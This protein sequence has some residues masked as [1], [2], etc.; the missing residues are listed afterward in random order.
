MKKTVLL[1]YFFLAAKLF[2]SDLPFT[3]GV[4]LTSWFQTDNV[5]SISFN[6]FTKK[7]FV[8]IQSLGFDHIRLPLNMEYMTGGAPDYE[9]DPLFFTLLDNVV[10]WAEEL[11]LYLILDNHTFDSS[12]D[13]PED[14]ENVLIPIWRQM[15]EHYKNRSNYIIYE[16]LN[17]PHGISDST[18]INIQG[19]VLET[20]RAVD[21]THKI[22]VTGAQNS[23]YNSL[24]DI[25]AYE[26]DNLIYTFHFYD[27][28]LFTH[29]GATWSG[30]G[31]D[32][33]KNVPFPYDASRMPSWQSGTYDLWVVSLFGNYKNDGTVAK[34]KNLINIARDFRD[35][36]NVPIYCGE[37]GVYI[38]N[39]PAEDR[40]T[41]YSLVAG[42]LD[43]LDIPWTM[44][45]YQG[46]FGLFTKTS[47]ALFDY[48]LNIPL[49]EALGLNV[50][51]QKDELE[52]V[53]DSSEVD[54]FT[55]FA[56][57]D[58]KLLFYGTSAVNLYNEDVPDGNEFSIHWA[59]ASQYDYL[60]FDF[61]PDRDFSYLV[62]KGY[63][64]SF[65]FKGNAAS[66]VLDVRFV[67]A[68][69]D[70]S[71]DKPWR[72]KYNIRSSMYPSDNTWKKIQIPLSSF[73]E[74]GAY[75]N[76]TWYNPEGKFD[77]TEIN[78]FEFIAEHGDFN[79]VEYSLADI[80]LVDP[81]VVSVGDDEAVSYKFRLMQ[82]YP[83]PFNP[84]T[85]IQYQIPETENVSIK[86]YD[87]LG[88]E[89]AVLVNQT[90]SAGQYKVDFDASKLASGV[91][92]YRLSAGDFTANK[93]MI[94]L[95]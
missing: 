48:D 11:N 69:P 27:P 52:F 12:S 41:W 73:Y 87:M 40:V 8:Q 25:P 72:M 74:H 3:K 77:W 63:Y 75:F 58:M 18:W 21:D 39:S 62:E 56:G 93:K 46:G 32:R 66:S 4:N 43:S 14:Y 51:E 76:G 55:N 71:V 54:L 17:E 19:Q 33:I 94:L 45:D 61:R 95:K 57:D 15:A 65:W 49:V 16:I 92:L 81:A 90:Q 89:V 42:Y 82:N 34:V 53:T 30:R 83:N 80:K 13:T 47:N 29:Q 9:I 85:S 7:D 24:E 84:S 70:S 5:R 37:Y 59:D 79:N 88:R 44:W 50:P 91:Y 23:S 10:D 35:E 64:L 20:I 38:P 67:D 2:C 60:R 86:V 31:L 22:I 26:D 68:I 1:F 36:R 28:F 6:T 78:Y